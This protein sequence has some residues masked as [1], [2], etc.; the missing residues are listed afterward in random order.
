MGKGKIIDLIERRV[1]AAYVRVAE[2]LFST[3]AGSPDSG[4]AKLVNEGCGNGQ[5][6]EG[7][8]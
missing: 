8:R 4:L 7:L 1:D 2:E 3:A 6:S 5:V